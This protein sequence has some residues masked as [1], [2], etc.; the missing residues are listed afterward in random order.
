[1]QQIQRWALKLVG[2]DGMAGWLDKLLW[3]ITQCS[4]SAEPVH[5]RMMDKRLCIKRCG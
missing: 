1:V 3:Y 5:D 4:S 2:S